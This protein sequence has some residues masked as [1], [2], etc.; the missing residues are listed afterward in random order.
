VLSIA[1]VALTMVLLPTASVL[2]DSVAHP[3]A[4]LVLLIGKWFVF[5]GAGVRLGL[6]GLRQVFQPAF[7]ANEI[8][9]MYGKEVFP[10]VRELGIAH[11]AAAVTGLLSLVAPSFVV[12][13]AISAGI[14]YGVAGIRHALEPRRS[15][16]KSIA[17]VSDLW[18]FFVLATFLAATTFP[19]ER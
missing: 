10:L 16:N 1:I 13:V 11:T 6:A 4:P 2:A 14:F 19:L 8:F 15:L 7:T 17:M 3:A 5:W 18:I 12:P 9:H